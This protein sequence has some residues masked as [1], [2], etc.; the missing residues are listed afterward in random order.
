MIGPDFEL[1]GQLYNHTIVGNFIQQEMPFVQ[2]NATLVTIFAGVNEVNTITAALG[3]G[4][5]SS[6]PNGY[7]D[8]QARAFGADY[9][10]LLSGIRERAGAPRLVILNVPNAAGL[11]YL[12]GASL[13]QRQAAQRAAVGMTRTGVNTLVSSSVSVIDLITCIPT[14]PDMRS[15]PLK[16][17]GRSRPA[18]IPPRKAAAP[19][20]PSF[21]ELTA[22]PLFFRGPY[23]ARA[24]LFTDVVTRLETGLTRALP[25]PDAQTRLA[26]IPRR[27]W[28]LGF[29]PQR[30]RDAAGLLLVF[31]KNTTIYAKAA[32]QENRLRSSRL[33]NRSSRSEGRAKAGVL[34][35]TSEDAHIVL[36]VR[37]H[38]L[39]RHGGQVSLPGGVV[40]PGETFEQAALREAHE[41]IGLWLELVRVLGGL[42][43]LDIPV[44]GFRLHPIVAVSDARPALSPSDGEVAR[45]LE[46]AIDD[47]LD[48]AR[49]KHTT[50]ERGGVTLTI[51][52]FHVANEEIWGATA[53]VL[54]EFLALL[55]S[56]D[57]KMSV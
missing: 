42:T 1:L 36:T 44:S 52:A 56:V 49:L 19:R 47:L 32:E 30:I 23:V 8:N 22:S 45:I 15:S 26:P 24:V 12:A 57:D 27:E 37:A 46:V 10:T 18:R 4:A 38:A 5:G 40:E 28:P 20:W 7:I 9:A 55:G 21:R 48:P 3:G 6:D 25:G 39:G 33:P 35:S 17:Y 11:P 29:N 41:E 54:A 51:P 2:P 53:M 16:S 13:A 34:R 50:R 43:P 31:P 14:M